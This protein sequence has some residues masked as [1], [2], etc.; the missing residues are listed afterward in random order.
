MLLTQEVRDGVC[1]VQLHLDPT[2]SADPFSALPQVR[3]LHGIPGATPSK[4]TAPLQWKTADLLEAVIPISGRETILNTID[5]P[6]QQPVVLSPA[7]LPYSP[8]FEPDQP[9]RGPATLAQLA[10]TTGGKERVEIPQIWKELPSNPRYVELTPWLLILA[11]VLFLL[12]IFERR[13]GLLSRVRTGA[14]RAVEPEAAVRETEPAVPR[15]RARLRGLPLPGLR[16]GRDRM[17]SRK[18]DSQDPSPSSPASPS[19]ASARPGTAPEPSPETAGTLEAFRK[20]R[21]RAGRRTGGR[22][23]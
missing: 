3:T 17:P 2:R 14:R 19:S 7:C 21:E 23:S 8:E 1:F 11:V 22:Q 16:R 10:M 15:G 12:E 6:G 9:G 20:A 5:I 13:T 4:R 18:P